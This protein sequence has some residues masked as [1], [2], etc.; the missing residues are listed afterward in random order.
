MAQ[1]LRTILFVPGNKARMLEKARTLPADAV[2]LDLEDGVPLG[3]KGAARAAVRQALE[4]GAYGPQVILRVNAFGTGLVETDLRGAFTGGVHAVC[5][6]KAE[7]AREVEGLA[8]LL[9]GLEQEHGLPAGAVDILLMVETALGVLNAF[10]MGGVKMAGGNRRVHALCL[11]GE[12]LAH[13]L[14]AIRTEEGLELAQ[15]RAHLVLAAR[16]AGAQA[17]DTIYADLSDPDGLA[18]EAR[19]A[20]QL[21]YSGKLVIHPAQIEPVR[22]AFAP[23]EEEVA[24]ARRVVAAFEAAEARGDGVIALDGQMIDAPVVAR[25][26]EVL[27]SAAA[28]TAADATARNSGPAPPKPPAAR[29]Y[30]PD[31]GSRP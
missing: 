1:P 14:G 4:A 3:E 28:H 7:T 10:E 21:G 25:A 9:D 20:H 31:S 30:P 17:I 5:L 8:A 24:Q 26:R 16:A 18:A 6:S 11:G 29:P 27:A 2:M 22:Q 19:Q 13:N 23:T 12:D 15:A